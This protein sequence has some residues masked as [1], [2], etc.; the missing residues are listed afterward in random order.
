MKIVSMILKRIIHFLP[1]E[2]CIL[3]SEEKEIIDAV[4]KYFDK[5]CKEYD[6]KTV[7]DLKNTVFKKIFND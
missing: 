7:E 1:I 4:I 6:K 5:F 3:T 2:E